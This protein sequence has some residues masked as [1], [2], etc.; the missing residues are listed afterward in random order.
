MD[1]TANQMSDVRER[2]INALGDMRAHVLAQWSVIAKCVQVIPGNA[3]RCDQLT[4][5][6]LARF[7]VTPKS[8]V[9]LDELGRMVIGAYQG[10]TFDM[11]MIP[12]YSARSAGQRMFDQLAQHGL[13]IVRANEVT[14]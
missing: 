4:A 14:Q 3:T 11:T 9:T 10:P 13:A 1:E 12:A 2:L 6:N 8:A 7:E 5:S